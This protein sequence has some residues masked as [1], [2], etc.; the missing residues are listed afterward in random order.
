[1][2]LGCRNIFKY[3]C[4]LSADCLLKEAIIHY[5]YAIKEGDAQKIR[6]TTYTWS[7]SNFRNQV[8]HKKQG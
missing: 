5:F 3:F 1:M 2:I 8:T 4:L 6:N 7:N